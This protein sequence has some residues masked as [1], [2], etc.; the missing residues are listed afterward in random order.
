MNTSSNLTVLPLTQI[1]IDG[2]TIHQDRHGRF[3]L[4]DLHKASG[5]EVKNKPSNFLQNDKTQE[6]VEPYRVCRR[7]TFLRECPNDK[8][9]IY[10]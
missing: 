10:S 4:N 5:G 8:T 1:S 3:C 7:P 2:A 6:L 9:K